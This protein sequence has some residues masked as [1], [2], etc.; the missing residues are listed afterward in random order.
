MTAFVGNSY[1]MMGTKRAA[2]PI[3]LLMR[4]YCARL[5]PVAL[6]E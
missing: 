4:R 5:G 2:V 6:S 1:L 3:A